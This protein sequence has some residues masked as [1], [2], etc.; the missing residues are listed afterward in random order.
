MPGVFML[1]LNAASSE[2][3]VLLQR[4]SGSVGGSYTWCHP[5][6][7][8]ERADKAII[9]D[10]S[11]LSTPAG[12]AYRIQATWCAALSE[13]AEE[14]GGGDGPSPQR[15][16]L[17]ERKYGRATSWSWAQVAQHHGLSTERVFLPPRVCCENS[18]RHGEVLFLGDPAMLRSPGNSDFLFVIN[19]AVG[20]G[21]WCTD[22]VPRAIAPWRGEIEETYRFSSSPHPHIEHGYVWANLSLVLAAA[23]DAAVKPI[24]PSTMSLHP[25]TYKPLRDAAVLDRIEKYMLAHGLPP[26][27]SGLVAGGASG[28]GGGGASGGGAASPIDLHLT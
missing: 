25:A 12:I 5:C 18:H 9:R 15:L 1:R 13:L 20:D 23:G 6:G 14:A 3:E 2:Y 11:M 17:H 8:S 16:N 7:S 10:W 27:P 28:G 21:Q 26:L 4:R 19:S 24:P 22:W